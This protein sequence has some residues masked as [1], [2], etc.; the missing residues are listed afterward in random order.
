MVQHG[1]HRAE[2]MREAA[3]TVREAGFEP[4]MATAIADKQQRVA[5]KASAGLFDGLEKDA[6]W[7]DY[8][9]R[10]MG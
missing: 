9:D 5:E 6:L 3:N 4:F 7:Q 2:E 1:K 8:A 10:L